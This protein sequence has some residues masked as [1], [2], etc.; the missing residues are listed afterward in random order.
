[1]YDKLFSVLLWKKKFYTTC[2]IDLH[3]E[4]TNSSFKLFKSTSTAFPVHGVH[5]VTSTRYA[6]KIFQTRLQLKYCVGYIRLWSSSSRQLRHDLQWSHEWSNNTQLNPLKLFIRTATGYICYHDII[7][8]VI[9]VRADTVL[10]RH[11]SVISYKVG[12]F[13]HETQ[14]RHVAHFIVS[15]F[16]NKKKTRF[17]V[18]ET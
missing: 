8:R 17:V 11:S 2:P 14:L 7:I 10:D 6:S 18:I 15:R 12:I 13:Q 16:A 5:I 3:V 4:E 1:M 9:L